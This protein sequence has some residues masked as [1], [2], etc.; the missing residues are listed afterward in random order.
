MDN[1]F[2]SVF[3]LPF[4]FYAVKYYKEPMDAGR[5]I[6][7]QRAV[8]QSM[9]N[10]YLLG[11]CDTVRYEYHVSLQKYGSIAIRYCITIST[12]R[13]MCHYSLKNRAVVE[14]VTDKL[15]SKLL[16]NKYRLLIPL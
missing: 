6:L 14:Y 3:K 4:L 7:T 8:D 15:I 11:I 5:L 13:I 2:G 16:Y 9:L 12:V 10:H 1:F